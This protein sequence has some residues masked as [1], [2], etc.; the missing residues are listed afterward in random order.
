MISIYTS[1]Y[2]LISMGFSWKDTFTHWLAFLKN[3]GQI[4]VA[5]NT[6]T[7]DTAAKVRAFFDQYVAEHPWCVTKINVVEAEIPYTD[8]EFDGKLKALALSHCTEP[9]AILLDCDEIIPP[10]QRNLWMGM[11][12]EL[13]NRRN[14]DALLVPVIDLIG[15]EQHFKSIGSKWYLHRNTPNITRGVVGFARREDGTFDTSKS[16]S[17]EA[18]YKDSGELVRAGPILTPSLPDFLK[19]TNLESGETP[20]VIHLGWINLEQRLKQTEFWKPHWENREG[21]PDSQPKTTLADLEK[22]RR[23]RHGLA[24]W[25][26]IT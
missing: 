12:R 9:Y 10:H 24:D 6:S 19:L 3:S 11:V 1:A 25:R 15:D 23:L 7:D 18:I 14:I 22:I 2:N 4:V 17:C 26:V 21:K 16:D 5:V 20:Y 13:E 8:R